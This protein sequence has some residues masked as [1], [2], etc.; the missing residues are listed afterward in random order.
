[1]LFRSTDV[2]ILIN[3]V[4]DTTGTNDGFSPKHV[5]VNLQEDIDI[6]DITALIHRVLF[7]VWPTAE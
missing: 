7:G 3:Q 2:T 4:L 5:D 6:E 1:M